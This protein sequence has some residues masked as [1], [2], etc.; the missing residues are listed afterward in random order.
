MRKSQWIECWRN[1]NEIREGCR[2]RKGSILTLKTSLF[3]WN[4][5]VN[6]KNK[7]LVSFQRG[8]SRSKES[9]S[10]HASWPCSCQCSKQPFQRWRSSQWSLRPRRRRWRE[11]QSRHRRAFQIQC[12]CRKSRLEKM[13]WKMEGWKKRTE[14]K[15]VKYSFVKSRDRIIK[16]IKIW[17]GGIK[18]DLLHLTSLQAHHQT[19]VMIDV[20]RSLDFAAPLLRGSLKS[21][22]FLWHGIL[23]QVFS[24]SR[25]HSSWSQSARW[26]SSG[27]HARTN[28]LRYFEQTIDLLLR[29]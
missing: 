27:Q 22:S 3:S 4:Q 1:S 6:E 5:S 11:G 21:P 16:W 9:K 12:W 17:L 23:T 7:E 24:G 25:V 8:V 2:E 29:G 20:I 28:L 18:M 15:S 19:L 13:R 10:T 14:L 26:R